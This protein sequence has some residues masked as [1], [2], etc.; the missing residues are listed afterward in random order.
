MVLLPSRPSPPL[1]QLSNLHNL[2]QTNNSPFPALR[3]VLGIPVTSRPYPTPRQVSCGC[4][5][6]SE[7]GDKAGWWMEERRFFCVCLCPPHHQINSPSDPGRDKVASRFK[8]MGSLVVMNRKYL[9]H[10]LCTRKLPF[11]WLEVQQRNHPRG[12]YHRLGAAKRG[13]GLIIASSPG[14]V[15]QGWVY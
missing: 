12:F 2:Q 13:K 14:I 10:M 9:L 11:P 15:S 3:R 6:L 4:Y 8:L 1:R 5:W 7:V